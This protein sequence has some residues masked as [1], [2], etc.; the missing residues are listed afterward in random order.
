MRLDLEFWIDFQ[1]VKTLDI[2]EDSRGYM[3]LDTRWF[4]IT[5]T[6]TL[7]LFASGYVVSKFPGSTDFRFASRVSLISPLSP[8]LPVVKLSMQRI[9]IR[10]QVYSIYAVAQCTF[11]GQF[12]APLVQFPRESIGI[13]RIRPAVSSNFERTDSRENIPWSGQVFLESPSS[14]LFTDFYLF[15]HLQIPLLF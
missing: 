2:Y 4:E 13:A 9:L 10:D 12:Q 6:K 1:R 8:P 7:I 11:Q 15:H 14:S 5:F 3:Y